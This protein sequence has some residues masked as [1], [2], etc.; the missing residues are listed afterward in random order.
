MKILLIRLLLL[1]SLSFSNSNGPPSG[2]ANNFPSFQNCTV[3]HSGTENSGNG[4]IQFLGLPSFYIPGETYPIEVFVSG[5]NNRGYGFQ[6]AAM[7][8]D[9]T[10]GSFSL[11]SSSN[12]SEMNGNYIQQSSRNS[13]GNW[14]F[15]WIAPSSDI[16]E[17]T[18]SASGLATGGSS[19]YS[20]DDVY[21]TEVSVFAQPLSI[22]SA[23]EVGNFSL[24]DNYPNPFNPYTNIDYVL[25]EEGFIELNIYDLFGNL[26][27]NLVN[28]R[29]SA[30]LKNIQWNASNDMG[31]LVSSGTYIYSL[32]SESGTQNKKMILLK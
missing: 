13:D 12:Y 17:I 6:A 4:S 30:G 25:K 27:I 23:L 7:K 20:G 10:A 22:Y 28:E 5:S 2:Y 3:C 8:N 11:N 15:D 9:V 14:V 1:I 24:H 31:S 18:F 16:G 26:I 19:G 32:K 29:Q 21:T